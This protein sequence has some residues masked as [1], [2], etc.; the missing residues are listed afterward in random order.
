MNIR[1]WRGFAFCDGIGEAENP[2]LEE[3]GNE[4]LMLEGAMG[5]GALDTE[6]PV[7]QQVS[8]FCNNNFR[9]EA[10]LL[11]VAMA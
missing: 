11:V 5:D 10:T 6:P 3:F 9:D 2:D 7:M 8:A 1:A 4:R